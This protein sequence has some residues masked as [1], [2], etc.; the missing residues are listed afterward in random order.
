MLHHS[1]IMQ[2]YFFLIQ[3]AEENAQ[4]TDAADSK[5]DRGNHP[6]R[7]RRRE[8]CGPAQRKEQP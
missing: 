5:P 7:Q 6:D 8:I 2:V 4:I 1:V 3:T